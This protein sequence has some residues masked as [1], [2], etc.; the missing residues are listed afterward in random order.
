MRGQ[1]IKARIPKS[2]YLSQ[3]MISSVVQDLPFANLANLV[4]KLNML[5][6]QIHM[7]GQWMLVV[8][9]W[10]LCGS[11]MLCSKPA[12]CVASFWE[13]ISERLVHAA[14]LYVSVGI[15]STGT[16]SR[17]RHDQQTIHCNTVPV[18]LCVRLELSVTSTASAIVLHQSTVACK[19]NILIA[20]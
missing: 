6:P 5:S 15:S 18:C 1:D 20:I 19:T 10:S 12:F 8:P 13:C 7:Q 3:Y 4:R 11:N 16:G 9:C 2:G 14:V 17:P